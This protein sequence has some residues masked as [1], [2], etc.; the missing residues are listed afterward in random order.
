MEGD[1]ADV[2]DA[3]DVGDYLLEGQVPGW[4]DDVG[5]FHFCYWDVPAFDFWWVGV[6]REELHVDG[7]GVVL[8]LR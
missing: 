4:V 7:V 2:G 6:V 3:V 8:S 5:E 1:S